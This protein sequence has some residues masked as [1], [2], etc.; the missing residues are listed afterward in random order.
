M[1]HLPVLLEET[2]GALAGTKGSVFVDCTF[3]GGGHT[4]RLFSLLPHATVIAFDKDPEAETRARVRFS[5]EIGNGQLRFVCADYRELSDRLKEMAVPCVDG[6]ML[7]AGVS[8]FQLD[9]T[10]RGFSF[11][12]SGPLD[13]RMDTRQQVSAREIVNTWSPRELENILY[14]YGEEKMARRIVSAIVGERDRE[15]VADTARLAE[16]VRQAYPAA[17]R[18]ASQI[19]PATRTFQAIRIAVNRELESLERFLEQIPGVL[20]VGGVAAV[21]SF[22]SLEDRLV[23]ERFR[24]LSQDCICPPEV[25]TCARCHKPP[26]A[27]LTKKPI[28]PSGAEIQNNPRAR[29]AKLRILRRV[30]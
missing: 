29:S 15:P 1:E 5:R 2:A 10:E 18:R 17:L 26:A 16:I 27:L 8:S 3:G 9:D 28:V 30:L 6:V 22:H 20:C 23:K 4:A 24:W 11:S 14:R 21:I 7:D 12:R 25:I 13:M 19:H